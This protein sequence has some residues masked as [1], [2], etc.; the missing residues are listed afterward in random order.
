[1]WLVP[2]LRDGQLVR[3]HWEVLTL[4]SSSESL[5]EADTVTR[6]D[7]KRVLQQKW[8]LSGRV[9]VPMPR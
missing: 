7:F 2:E 8:S 5:M 1:M 4:E 6:V 9:P 3:G